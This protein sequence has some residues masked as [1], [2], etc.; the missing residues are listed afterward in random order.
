MAPNYQIE[1]MPSII[2]RLVEPPTDGQIGTPQLSG[3][4]RLIAAVANDLSVLLNTR[5]EEGLV[6]KEFEQSSTSIVNFG[7]PDVMKLSLRSSADQ[8]R[9]RR[10]LEDAIKT[11]E[12]RLNNVVVKSAGWEQGSPTLRFRVEAEIMLGGSLEPVSFEPSWKGDS[13]RFVVSGKRP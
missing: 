12:P 9:L 10:W 1:L 13:G 4:E 7:I 5:R 3:E 2:D 11:F 8:A 6:P